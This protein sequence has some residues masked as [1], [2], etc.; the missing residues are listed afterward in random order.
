MKA[1]ILIQELQKLIE[2]RGDFNV[3]NVLEDYKK[4]RCKT[5]YGRGY[6]VSNGNE[7]RC[8][9]CE[10]DGQHPDE[11]DWLENK[12]KD[13]RLCAKAGDNVLT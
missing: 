1:S 3:T 13:N 9:F 7:Y 11:P 5:C 2:Q 6:I 4:I 8:L 10:G 12:R